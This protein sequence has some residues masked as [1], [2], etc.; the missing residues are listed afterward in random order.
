MD[1]DIP[2]YFG[3]L[4]NSMKQFLQIVFWGNEI[5]KSKTMICFGKGRCRNNHDTQCLERVG[6]NNEKDFGGSK[7]IGLNDRLHKTNGKPTW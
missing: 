4:R 1:S 7:T 6:Y 3:N 2:S 5:V